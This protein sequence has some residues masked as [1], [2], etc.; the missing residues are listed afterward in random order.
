MLKLCDKLIFKFALVVSIGAVLGLC[1][2]F[3]YNGIYWPS[4]MSLVTLGDNIKITKNIEKFVK[5]AIL[6]PPN[7]TIIQVESYR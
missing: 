3:L 2:A 5:S 4:M 1:H 6:S 7:K